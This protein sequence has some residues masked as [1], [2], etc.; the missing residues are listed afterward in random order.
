MI[1]SMQYSYLV[2]PVEAAHVRSRFDFERPVTPVVGLSFE[3]APGT[4]MVRMTLI[5]NEPDVAVAPLPSTTD[6]VNV[7]SPAVVGVPE[8]TPVD[9]VRLRPAGRAPDATDQVYGAAPPATPSDAEYGV[10]VP[11]PGKI[12]RA[13]V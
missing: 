5:D 6:T 12:G 13:H 7:D 3:N 8:M 2:A 4:G 11:P 1:V 9:G 10:D